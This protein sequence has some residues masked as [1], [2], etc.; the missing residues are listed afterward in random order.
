MLFEANLE[1]AAREALEMVLAAHDAEGRKGIYFGVKFIGG[2]YFI[3]PR[4][5]GRVTNGHDGTY[6]WHCREK[7]NRLDKEYMADNSVVS[8]YQSRVKGK[9][10]GGSIRVHDSQGRLYAIS[11]SGLKDEL[12]DEAISLVIA[13]K[14][15]LLFMEE[16]IE[17]A[18]VSS[19]EIFLG[20]ADRL[21]A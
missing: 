6:K 11:V 5:V 16:A 15:R 7:A 14:T 12:A 2:G 18:G 8:S 17:T 20:L 21:A 19:N 1:R 4:L 3:K 10:Y 9:R 13:V